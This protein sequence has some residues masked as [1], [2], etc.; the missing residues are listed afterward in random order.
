MPGLFNHSLAM[1]P[2]VRSCGAGFSQACLTMLEGCSKGL[3][4]QA[5]PFAD[6]GQP[7]SRLGGTCGILTIGPTLGKAPCKGGRAGGF[8]CCLMSWKIQLASPAVKRLSRAEAS[9]SC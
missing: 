1:G 5:V 2:I 7:V 4:K 9:L 6:N 8:V 3:N